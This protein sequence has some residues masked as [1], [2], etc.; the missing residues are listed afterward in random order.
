M[1]YG[2]A[3]AGVAIVGLALPIRTRGQVAA[4]LAG[5]ATIRVLNLSG[6]ALRGTLPAGLLQWSSL[7]L[8]LSNVVTA[9]T[10][11]NSSHDDDDCN[12]P[13]SLRT[14][15]LGTKFDELGQNEA[16]LAQFTSGCPNLRFKFEG[17]VDGQDSRQ[18]PPSP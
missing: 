13:V 17:I 15:G 7:I 12:E 1:M 14:T 8:S 5:L 16:R 11:S 9:S 3:E 2:E 18:W 4:S 6:N 10:S